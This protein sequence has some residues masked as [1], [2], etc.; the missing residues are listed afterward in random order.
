[1]YGIFNESSGP[2]GQGVGEGGKDF[3]IANKSSYGFGTG[4]EAV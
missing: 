1:M 3:S 2:S 4:V